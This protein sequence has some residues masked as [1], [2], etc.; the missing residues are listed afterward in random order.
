MF[1]AQNTFGWFVVESRS[2][3]VARLITDEHTGN[4][5]H[6]YLLAIIISATIANDETDTNSLIDS[7]SL[8]W[9]INGL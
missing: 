3:M 4:I 6:H 8:I 5:T 7:I 9:L 1:K 2:N